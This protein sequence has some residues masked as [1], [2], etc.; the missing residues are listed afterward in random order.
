MFSFKL[1]SGKKGE[2]EMLLVPVDI[3]IVVEVTEDFKKTMLEEFKIALDQVDS[4]INQIGSQ[5]MV[6]VSELFKGT[7]IEHISE[8]AKRESQTGYAIDSTETT[9]LEFLRYLKEKLEKEMEKLRNLK[10]GDIVNFRTVPGMT[11]LQLGSDI[12]NLGK[13]TVKVRDWKVI[14]IKS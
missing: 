4:L 11:V 1:L 8:K 13:V 5:R 2:R 6:K 3:S 12:R 14:E 9:K 7:L 10:E